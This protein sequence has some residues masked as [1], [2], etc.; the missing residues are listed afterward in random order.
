[1]PPAGLIQG[2]ITVSI[3]KLGI[4]GLAAVLWVAVMGVLVVFTAAPALAASLE[5]PETGVA[6]PT[7]STAVL[8]GVVNPGGAGVKGGWQFHYAL[9]EA[10]CTNGGVAPESPEVTLGAKEGVEQ[11]VTGLQP[12]K[13]YLFCLVASDLLGGSVSGALVP[14]ETLPAPP[15]LSAGSEKVSVVSAAGASLE[16]TLNANNEETTYSFEY[17]TQGKT[18]AGEE[19]KGTIVTVPGAP[20]TLPAEFVESPVAVPTAVLAANTTYF[21]RVVAE[22]AQSKTEV[23]PVQGP[24]ESFT[25][26]PEAP[27]T[28][29]PA[30]SITATTAVLEGVLNPKVAVAVKAGWYFAYS[31]GA[32]CT[33]AAPGSGE[34]AHEPEVAAKALAVKPTKVTGLEPNQ[35]YTFCLVATNAAGAQSTPGNPQILETKPA[36]PSIEAGSEKAPTPTLTPYEATLEAQINPNNQKTT[37]TFEY[38]TSNTLTGT[39]VKVSDATPLEGYG[40]EVASVSTGHVLIPGTTYYYRVVA[41]NATGTTTDPTIASFNTPA[42]TAPEIVSETSAV[43]SP[44]AATLTT[45]VNPDFQPTTCEFEYSTDPTLATG[46]KTQACAASL[47]EGGTGASGTAT[48]SGLTSNT[49]YYY[50]VLAT[51]GSGATTDPKIE[52]FTTA[53]ALAPTVTGE[54]AP[55]TTALTATI[56]AQVNPSFQETAC[57]VLYWPATA[58]ESA[59]LTL[60]CTP[61]GAKL[62]T[63]NEAVPVTALLENLTPGVVYDYRVIATNA[64]G[65]STLGAPQT[66]TTQIAATITTATAGEVAEMTATLTGATV[67]P[68]GSETTYHYSY[69]NQSGYEFAFAN[70][71]GFR[72]VNPAFN[73][74]QYGANTT[75]LTAGTGVTPEAIPAVQLTALLPGTTYHYAL[76]ATNTAGTTVI[77]P[78]QTFTTSPAPAAPAAAPESTT[79]P[80]AATLPSVTT[81]FPNLTG[82]APIPAPKE[83]A[84][85]TKK[86]AKK[87]SHKKPKK[88][89]KKTKAKSNKK[90]HKS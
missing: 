7:A 53:T 55:A 32:S 15:V 74:Y 36:S 21:Y 10:E 17:S 6:E 64:T 84:A 26:A 79:P 40:D 11:T 9:S 28:L 75:D 66:F 33:E 68:N 48:L 22:N 56:E 18:G 86:P 38:S 27:E 85:K 50:R 78:D 44:F 24:V 2:G 46:V 69:I 59:A 25:S 42:V 19:L 23:K 82:I 71:K 83:P 77:G 76:I 51:N 60:P 30:Q 31:T 5:A 43:Q 16:A 89:S 62:G 57:S 47:G 63:G 37:Y 20:G 39:V 90:A 80:P 41:T 1:M 58:A 52:E 13:K 4:G 3:R 67:N 88:K 45:E 70:G 61:T 72:E 29:T 54:T 34:T 81:V 87:K 14:F 73:P 12:A 65:T 49:T 35:K 8:H